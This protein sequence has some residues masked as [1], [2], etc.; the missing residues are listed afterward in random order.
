MLQAFL[1]FA[2]TERREGRGDLFIGKIA[3]AP[4]GL[5]ND[6]GRVNGKY[7]CELADKKFS[8]REDRRQFWFGA[9]DYY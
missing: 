1:V 3:T 7:E 6:I 2:R 4:V 9:G 5:R 8:V